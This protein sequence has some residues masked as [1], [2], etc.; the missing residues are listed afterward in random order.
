MT[1]QIYVHGGVYVPVQ[2]VETF[3]KK[4]T[5]SQIDLER[6]FIGV[7]KGLYP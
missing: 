2:T 1:T 3:K 5:S 6:E 7:A 4:S